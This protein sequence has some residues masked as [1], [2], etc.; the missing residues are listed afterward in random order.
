MDILV[1]KILAN[2]ERATGWELWADPDGVA[3]ALK[4]AREVGSDYEKFKRT[5]TRLAAKGLVVRVG[6]ERRSA[7]ADWAITAAGTAEA[8]RAV[9]GEFENPD[10]KTYVGKR[11]DGTKGVPRDVWRELMRRHKAGELDIAFLPSKSK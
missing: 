7:R 5:V 8:E 11:L 6:D 10:A 1:L 4:V 3:D 9:R 2:W